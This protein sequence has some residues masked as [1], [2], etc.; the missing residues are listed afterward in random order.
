LSPTW[1]PLAPS[2]LAPRLA[3]WLIDAAPR[4]RVAI[5]GPP[6]SGADDLAQAVVAALRELGRP[7]VQVRARDF[8]RD[9]ALRLEH[10]RTDVE[11]FARWVDTEA[12]AREVLVPALERRRY[13]PSLRDP[14]SNRATREPEREL[15]ADAVLIVSGE[16]LLGHGLPFERTVHLLMSPA[17]RTRRCAPGEEWTL[18][19]YDRYDAAVAPA[20]RADAV[21]KLE[22]PRHPAI[23]IRHDRHGG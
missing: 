21:V 1:Q 16:L 22:D 10:G 19:A 11:S 7:A 12:L 9:A 14:V 23:V 20:E 15:T 2:A 5:D 4:S 6:M 3:Q 18:P 17:A 13:L 8:W